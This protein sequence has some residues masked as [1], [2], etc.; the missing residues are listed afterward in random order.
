MPFLLKYFSD[1]KKKQLIVIDGTFLNSK[2]KGQFLVELGRDGDNQI[3]PIE[4]GNGEKE[5]TNNWEW[6]VKKLQEDLGLGDETS[7]V[8]VSNQQKVMLVIC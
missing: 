2:V 1:E 8:M 6:F 5:N 3:Y 7:F 4:W